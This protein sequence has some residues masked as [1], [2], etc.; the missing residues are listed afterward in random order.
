[1]PAIE[2]LPIEGD[3][4]FQ[5]DGCPAH[6]TNIVRNY[7]NVT[8]PRRCIGRRGANNWPARS[9]D[10]SLNDFFTGVI[11]KIIFTQAFVLIKFRRITKQNF[12]SVCSNHTRYF[13]K[14]LKRI[15]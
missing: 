12:R 8:F 11:S 1:M 14:R 4:W 5:H 10:L 13:T 2:E 6:N 3:I 15:L 9:P 7:S